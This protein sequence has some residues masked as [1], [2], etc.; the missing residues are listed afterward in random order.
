MRRL[1]FRCVYR[2]CPHEYQSKKTTNFYKERNEVKRAEFDAKIS[3]LSPEKLV[4][5]DESGV[6]Q[7]MCKAKAWALRGEKVYRPVSGKHFARLNMVGGLKNG[8]V[9]ALEKYKTS[10]TSPLFEKWFK[11]K[12]CPELESGDFVILDNATFHSKKK[13]PEIAKEFGIEI[14]FLPAYSPDKN[15]IEQVWANLKRWLR[16]N[17][18]NYKTIQNAIDSYFKTD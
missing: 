2:T 6:D 1:G 11:E 17:S 16:K 9:I 7:Y 4:Y 13:L 5:I 14:I 15:P 12:L 18:T 8:K 10:T 3:Q